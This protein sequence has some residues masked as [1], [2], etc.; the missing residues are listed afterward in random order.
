MR[1]IRLFILFV[2]GL[3]LCSVGC[4]VAHNDENEAGDH[5][6]PSE[7][8]VAPTRY[9]PPQLEQE[10]V[11]D[12]GLQNLPE[13]NEIFIPDALADL[14][15]SVDSDYYWYEPEVDED[16]DDGE[17]DSGRWTLP[18]PQPIESPLVHFW[19]NGTPGT[20]ENFS[21]W[22]VPLVGGGYRVMGRYENPGNFDGRLLLALNAE[23]QFQPYVFEIPP[24]LI[25]SAEGGEFTFLIQEYM[26]TLQ[27]Y[28]FMTNHH[29]TFNNHFQAMLTTQE[30]LM[31]IQPVTPE[32]PEEFDPKFEVV[33]RTSWLELRDFELSED[34][35]R[36][37][38]TAELID[39][40][41]ER[42]PFW[43]G[44]FDESLHMVHEL[45]INPLLHEFQ[46]E[47]P[48]IIYLQREFY[49]TGV[50]QISL[51]R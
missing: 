10:E 36:I 29:S 45:F 33:L 16:E 43:I 11:W 40:E 47:E 18:I 19:L 51:R 9:I 2:L 6:P 21:I 27:T 41:A 32:V 8:V 3:L 38:M 35:M 50:T 39:E 24:Y 22:I 4:G 12:I 7:E 1:K 48:R 23:N 20:R 31:A 49:L 28:T 44:F 5:P 30:R 15:W 17:E 34:R 46:L 26:G 13:T 42:Y 25:N 14:P 37:A